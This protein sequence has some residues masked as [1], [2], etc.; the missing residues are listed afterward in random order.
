MAGDGVQDSPFRSLLLPFLPPDRHLPLFATIP[1]SPPPRWR[2]GD[3]YTS[4]SRTSTTMKAAKFVTTDSAGRAA[5]ATAHAR[6]RAA[7]EHRRQRARTAGGGAHRTHSRL[8]R[9]RQALSRLYPDF[10]APYRTRTLSIRSAC[11]ETL[12]S[13]LSTDHRV[14]ILDVRSSSVQTC[15]LRLRQGHTT[16]IMLR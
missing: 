16:T 3:R 12:Q 9:S 7:V 10:P 14:Q 13:S 1:L 15:T 4:P 2:R 5:A 11:L 8:R 6:W